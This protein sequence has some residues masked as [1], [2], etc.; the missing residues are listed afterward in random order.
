M[1]T[2]LLALA[3]AVLALLFL[4]GDWQAEGTLRGPTIAGA[5]VIAARGRTVSVVGHCYRPGRT[6]YLLDAR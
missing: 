6:Y 4:S 2:K 1:T 3:I 5:V